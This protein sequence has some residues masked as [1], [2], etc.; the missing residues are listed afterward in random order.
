MRPGARFV[1]ADK[2]VGFR[3]ESKFTE[4]GLNDN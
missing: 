3:R 1:G 2:K 4:G